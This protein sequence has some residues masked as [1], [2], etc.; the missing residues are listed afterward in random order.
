[1]TELGFNYRL[2][3]FA[4]AL[5]QSQLQKLGGW[6]GKRQEIAAQYEAA[7]ASS[8]GIGTLAVPADRTSAW[9][10]YP[11]RFLGPQSAELRRAA[12]EEMREAGIGVNV[13]YLPV[14]LHT[15]Y[16]ALG[17]PAGLCPVAEEAYDG[18]LSLPM[19][20]G[21]TPDEQEKVIGMVTR[22]AESGV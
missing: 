2:S 20:P 5:G 19:W 13:H 22:I 15:Y 7:F 16:A 21:L 9:H 8:E 14:Y 1:M 12:F 18:L 10:L 4:C 17:Y 3:D 6:V 11:V